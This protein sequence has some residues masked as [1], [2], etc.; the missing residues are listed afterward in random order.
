MS[1]SPSRPKVTK[2]L[3]R[4]H[5]HYEIQAC[6]GVTP[7]SMRSLRPILDTGAGANLIRPDLL[8]PSWQE[9]AEALATPP[10][11]VD[12]NGMDIAAH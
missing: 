6:L 4:A 8:P 3:S 1:S 9:Y 2:L 10:R 12:A 5:R 11:F 7:S